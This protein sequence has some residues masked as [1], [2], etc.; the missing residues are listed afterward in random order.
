M[1][2]LFPFNLTQ[3]RSHSLP[4]TQRAIAKRCCVSGAALKELAQIALFFWYTFRVEKCVR[5]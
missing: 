2:A 4:S 1:I 5:L 3:T